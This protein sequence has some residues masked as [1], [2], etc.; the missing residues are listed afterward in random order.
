MAHIL[1]DYRWGGSHGIGRFAIEV[2]R[3]LPGCEA[4]PCSRG[5]LGLLE[6]FELS[7]KLRRLRPDVYFSPGF[8]PP[9]DAP[10]PVVFTIHDL[11][12]LH[13]PAESSA[14]K[15]LY[16][17]LVVRPAARRAA[18]VL[19]VSQFSR[20]QIVDWAGIEEDKVIVVGCGCSE[21]FTPDGPAH[22]EDR[23]Y[24]LHVGTH[25]PHK[26]LPKLLLAFAAAGLHHQMRLLLTGSPHE[27]LL[28]RARELGIV[29]AVRFIGELSDEQLAC[30][31]RGAA[32]VAVPSLHEGF[33]LSALEAMA[34]GTPVLAADA[35]SLP[36]VVGD[37]AVRV[38][39]RSTESMALGLLRIVSDECLRARC[40]AEG[41]RQARRF[42]WDITGR[43]VRDVLES[44]A[45]GEP[46]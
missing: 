19:T 8:N 36:E 23:P 26:N 5:P 30:R 32:A 2:I 15:K 7:W 17:R 33:G 4:M 18:A 38:H 41:L 1:A 42:S 22:A 20:Q 24:V 45:A 31:Y 6:P 21:H 10:V 16:Y 13:F 12:H 44:V 9:L 39:P 46:G 11:I 37:A 35:T 14:V 27:A 29:H 34:C 25:K 40:R 3:R 43:K 28:R